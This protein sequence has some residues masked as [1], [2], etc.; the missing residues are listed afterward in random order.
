MIYSLVNILLGK[1]CWYLPFTL[2]CIKTILIS[3]LLLFDREPHLPAQCQ[4]QA[5][6]DTMVKIGVNRFGHIGHL[7]TRVA[8]YYGKVDVVAINDPFIDFS[9]MSACSSMI[10]L[11]ARSKAQ[12][13]LRIGSLSSMES[14]SPTCRSEIPNIKWGDAG[15]EYVVELTGVFTTMEKAGTHLKGG[16]TRVIISAPSVDAPMSVMGENHDK[17]DNSMKTVSNA[18]CTTDYLAP[19]PR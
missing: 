8:F 7:V 13:R 9:Y 11:M 2:K 10:L 5:W 1:V 16:A 18:S 6:D 3:L 12:W 17:Y 19:W 14:P 4:P 15:D